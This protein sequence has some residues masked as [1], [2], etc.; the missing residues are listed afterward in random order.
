MLD[1]PDEESVQ[2]G[3]EDDHEDDHEEGVLIILHRGPVDVVPLYPYPHLLIVRE[4]LG[5]QAERCGGGEGLKQ[6]GHMSCLHVIVS[7]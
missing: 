1:V 7:G 6:A 2:E 3:V 4:V 5:P